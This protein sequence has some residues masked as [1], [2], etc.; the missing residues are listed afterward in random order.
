MQD[1]LTRAYRY[2]KVS[3]EFSTLAKGTPS[4]FSRGYYQRIAEQ[5]QTLADG[6]MGWRHEDATI[7][8]EKPMF[9]AKVWA[10]REQSGKKY[11]KVFLSNG[12]R[13]RIDFLEEVT[14]QQSFVAL[15]R[16]LNEKLGSC[17]IIAMNDLV[18]FDESDGLSEEQKR[19]LF[20]ALGSR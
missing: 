16:A 11:F 12:S 18:L 14:T 15:G 3:V 4:D 8:E 5:Y 13:V 7:P 20:K 1:P 10:Y 17:S 2:R 9:F 19:K 6:E